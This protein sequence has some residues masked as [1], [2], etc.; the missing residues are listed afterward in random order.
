M[1]DVTGTVSGNEDTTPPSTAP[2]AL[3]ITPAGGMGQETSSTSP[4]DA[5]NPTDRGTHSAGDDNSTH[6]EAG[7]GFSVAINPPG[8]RGQS[9]SMDAKDFSSRQEPTPASPPLSRLTLDVHEAAYFFGFSERSSLPDTARCRLCTRSPPDDTCLHW[10]ELPCCSTL[11]HRY[12]TWQLML[13]EPHGNACSICGHALLTRTRMARAVAYV[14]APDIPADVLQRCNRRD[15]IILQLAQSIPIGPDLPSFVFSQLLRASRL[16]QV[17]SMIEEPQLLGYT[18][19]GLFA[20][21]GIRTQYATHP[22]YPCANNATQ[23][24]ACFQQDVWHYCLEHA[25][26]WHS[27]RPMLV[28]NN[29]GGI[30]VL[31]NNSLPEETWACAIPLPAVGLP[32]ASALK[33]TLSSRDETNVWIRTYVLHTFSCT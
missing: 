18:S 29:R 22:G 2:L 19:T 5:E 33:G 6:P 27:S 31:G 16:L 24:F 4:S 17:A 12:C 25:P 20:S 14:L 3:P 23:A 15:W 1:N 8:D 10:V 28:S 7:R 13:A 11:V 30:V 21:P 32:S 26:A 9:G